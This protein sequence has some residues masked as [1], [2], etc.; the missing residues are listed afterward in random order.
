MK[1]FFLYQPLFLAEKLVM[2]GFV[3]KC[4]HKIGLPPS[5]SLTERIIP[6]YVYSCPHR[7]AQKLRKETKSENIPMMR[8]ETVNRVSNLFV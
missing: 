4:K 5:L 8:N 2:T 6:Y 7:C 1:L 3:Y